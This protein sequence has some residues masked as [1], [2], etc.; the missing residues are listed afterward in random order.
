MFF[1][2]H[3]PLDSMFTSKQL[4]MSYCI[5]YGI[6]VAFLMCTFLQ[7]HAALPTKHFQKIQ[8]AKASYLEKNRMNDCYVEKMEQNILCSCSWVVFS[9]R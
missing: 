6:Y 9:C 2:V 8:M 5:V 1:A 4:R 3:L 7:I